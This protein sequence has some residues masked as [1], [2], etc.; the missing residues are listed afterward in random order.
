[1]IRSKVRRL[2]FEKEEREGRKLTY[3]T[4]TEETG[5][6]SSTLSRLLKNDQIDRIDGQTLTTLCQYF[7]CGVGD[8]LEYVPDD[9]PEAHSAQT[10]QGTQE[11]QEVP[12]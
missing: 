12:V 2:R 10:D 6:S 4:L 7:N 1:M 11:G 5:L 3:E 8:L 9:V